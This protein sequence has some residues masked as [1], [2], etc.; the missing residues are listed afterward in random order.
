VG[1]ITPV[2]LAALAPPAGAFRKGGDFAAWVG[3]TP[4]QHSIGGKQ[5]LG[6]TSLRRLLIIGA[7]SVVRKAVRQANATE[8]WA[9]AD[10]GSQ[11]L[12]A[13]VSSKIGYFVTRNRPSA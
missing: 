6:T 1:R 13:A 10:A 8:S 3:L 9:R 2:A 7:S 11:G 5:K 4:L 12:P